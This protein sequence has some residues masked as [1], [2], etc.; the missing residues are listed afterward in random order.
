MR[1]CHGRFSLLC[2][3]STPQGTV[4]FHEGFKVMANMLT[5]TANPSNLIWDAA[6]S[7]R[8]AKDAP[9]YKDFTPLPSGCAMSSMMRLTYAVRSTPRTKSAPSC[10]V[11][12][13]EPGIEI[14]DPCCGSGGLLVN[15]DR[16]GRGDQRKPMQPCETSS[17][18]WN[19][20]H[21]DLHQQRAKGTRRA[22]P[23]RILTVTRC[24]AAFSN[25]F[26]SKINRSRSA[27]R[28]VLPRRGGSLRYLSG[29]FRQ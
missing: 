16:H 17:N 28:P 2:L 7:I 18:N 27:S 12:A 1:E 25:T 11:L 10:P 4:A 5:G 15:V 21:E 6:C 26:S 23:G 20:A 3:S 8:G 14:Y 19:S 9:K 29:Y 13:P 22:R 24:C